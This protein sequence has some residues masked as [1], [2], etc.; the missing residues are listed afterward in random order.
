[1]LTGAEMA[2]GPGPGGTCGSGFQEDAP[3]VPAELCSQESGFPSGL[4]Q[5]AISHG[6]NFLGLSVF[7]IG[8]HVPVRKTA[9]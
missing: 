6:P 9:F 2:Q 4:H 3:T 8:S 7:P 1:M 5:G